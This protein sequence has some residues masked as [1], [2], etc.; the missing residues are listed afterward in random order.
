MALPSACGCAIS[1]ID[2]DPD[3][4]SLS[5]PGYETGSLGISSVSLSSSV[6]SYIF[7][8]GRRYHRFREGA[9]PFPN[10]EREQERE[11][12]IDAVILEMCQQLHFAPIGANPQ[13]ILDLGTGIG[14]WALRMGDLYPSSSILGVDL[15]PIQPTWVPPN[16]K[17]VVDDVESLWL[18]PL[19][20]FD[21]IHTR[22]MAPAIRNWPGLMQQALDH[23][24][25]GGWFEVQE[26]HH[27]P[28]C[29]DGSIPLNYPVTQFWDSIIEALA[30]L[31]V[32][33]MATRVLVEVMRRVG[34]V[35]ITMRTFYIPIGPWPKNKTLKRAGLEWRTILSDGLQS[36]ALG[37]LT[38]GLGWTKEQ[39][40]VKLV[41]VR[42]A[43]M[44]DGV[45][46]YMPLHIIYGQKPRASVTK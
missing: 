43:Y 17:F 44:D 41:E 20:H 5:D 1:T 42:N 21:Y 28:Q 40:E 30:A 25:P 34:F 32:D 46:C 27:Y 3:R 7:E 13:K 36:T 22:H 37:P 2:P 38:R 29:H 4:N 6:Q 9:Y 11:A 15:S 24:K 33:L 19:D 14:I 39:V 35:N 16:V 18:Q 12:M 45:H 23:L 8:N 10:D 26:I 31:G